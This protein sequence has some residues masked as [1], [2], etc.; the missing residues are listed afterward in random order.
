MI[1]HIAAEAA[2]HHRHRLLKADAAA[3]EI[4]ELIFRDAA[5]AGLVLDRRLRLLGADIGVSVGGGLIADQHRIALAEITSARRLRPYLNQAAV[6][7]GRMAGA[8]PLAHDRGAGARAYMD[9]LG[10]G[11]GLLAIVGEGH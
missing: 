11:V 7:I 9:H 10:A 8:D 5:G 6:A 2:H 4:K 1:K 3:L